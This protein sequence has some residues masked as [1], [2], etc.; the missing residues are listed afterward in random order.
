[1]S[2]GSG[3]DLKNLCNTVVSQGNQ[4]YL[5]GIVEYAYNSNIFDG[6]FTYRDSARFIS[7]ELCK[8][9]PFS[10]ITYGDR[11]DLDEHYLLHEQLIPKMMRSF[12][13]T[14]DSYGATGAS[15]QD[16]GTDL[17]SDFYRKDPHSRQ[18]ALIDQVA[19]LKE[20]KDNGGFVMINSG[21]SY[22][23]VYSDMI[24]HMD[25]KGSEY[26]II[27]EFIPFYELALHGYVNYTGMPVN[28]CGSETDEILA[29]AE[30]GAGLCYSIM[31]EDPKTLQK[32][33]YPQ[34]YGSCYASVHDRLVET[35]SRYNNELG[36]TF[37]QE[38][39]GHENINDYVSVTEYADGTRVYVNYGYTDYAGD[40][41][42]VP[43]RDYKVVK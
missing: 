18:E 32:T 31:D 5:D 40:G 29:S 20:I 21:N 23:A 16:V 11:D 26:T 42:N 41:I 1:M 10:Q 17:A 34:Y 27:D 24:T 13:K 30:Y 38:M 15:F 7:R 6:F 39:T 25:L 22:A 43:A 9:Y 8:L 33:L 4:I 3:R 14:C 35:Y 36:H 2:L 19:V 28:I 12:V 37:N